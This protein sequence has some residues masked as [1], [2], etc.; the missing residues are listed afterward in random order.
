MS[1][2][3][4]IYLLVLLFIFAGLLVWFFYNFQ[5]TSKKTDIIS[6]KLKQNS[7][8]AQN[9]KALIEKVGQLILLPKDEPPSIATI[10]NVVLLQKD[11]PFYKNARNGDVVLIYFQAKKAYI[12]D[13]DKNIIVNVGPVFMSKNPPDVPV[14]PSGSTSSTT[15]TN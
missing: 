14:A 15:S 7:Q 5:L 1:Q 12:Y 10:N 8:T 4:K 3:R 6:E 11:Q 13:P 2:R 9:S